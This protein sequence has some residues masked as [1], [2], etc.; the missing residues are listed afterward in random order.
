LTATIYRM[1]SRHWWICL[2]IV[3]I[4]HILVYKA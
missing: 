1:K 3:C 2:H 4:L